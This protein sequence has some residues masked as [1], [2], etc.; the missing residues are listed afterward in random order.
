LVLY[1]FYLD[2]CKK[3]KIWHSLLRF[4]CEGSNLRQTLAIKLFLA[5]SSRL[6]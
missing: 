1:H 4:I 5:R 2:L 6:P 3:I